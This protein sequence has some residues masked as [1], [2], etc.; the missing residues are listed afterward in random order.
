MKTIKVSGLIVL[1]ALL[2]CN[3]DPGMNVNKTKPGKNQLADINSYFVQKDRERIQNY[4]ERKNLRMKE[5]ATGL[6]YTII[7][8][9]SGECFKDNDRIT[10]DYDCSLLDGSS[11]YSSKTLG[12]RE[13]V[14]GKSELETGLNEGLRL[15]KPGGEATFILPPFLAF[16]L[17]GDNNAIPRRA[18][19]VY[20]I[21]VL[22]RE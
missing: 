13:I 21:K 3:N 11:C 6:W 20:K 8:E 4:I 19:I 18:T 2:S 16:G 22:E 12:P 14:L 9:G 5:S 7:K 17:T 10:M 1:F 15:L